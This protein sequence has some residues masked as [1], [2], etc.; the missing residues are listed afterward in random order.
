[1]KVSRV[2][3][4]I[5]GAAALTAGVI[6]FGSWHWRLQGA[7]EMRLKRAAMLEAQ[8]QSLRAEVA[9]GAVQI[10]DLMDTLRGA[11]NRIAEVERQLEAEKKTNNPLR[12]QIEQMQ[13]GQIGLKD[14]LGKRDQSMAS[15]NTSLNETR[16]AN[17]ELRAE[18]DGQR[19]QIAKLEKELKSMG[20][21]EE[22][23][24]LQLGEA[25][26]SASDLQTKL[27]ETRRRLAESERLAGEL[28]KKNQAMETAA[29][30]T[31]SS[32]SSP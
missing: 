29:T 24:Q 32:V 27:D 17:K 26:K 14:N 12:R 2:F 25:R 28:Q 10:R 7:S 20:E 13:A 1:M 23:A 16:Q 6:V 8:D 30:N 3:V 22:A 4:R 21:R 11:S 15:L 19:V 31:A 9:A 5:L 18:G